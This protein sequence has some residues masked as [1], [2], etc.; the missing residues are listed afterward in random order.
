MR[1]FFKALAALSVALA[2]GSAAAQAAYPDK[3]VRIIVPFT[4]GGLADVLA[5]AVAVE[6]GKVWKQPV[7]VDNRPGAGTMIAGEATAKAPADGYTLLLANDATLSSNQYIYT[8][9]PY[10]PVKD[11]T[12]II[13]IANS[14]IALVAS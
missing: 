7:I 9:M 1:K 2:A 4:A 8:K 13:N 12:P 3:T 5:R 11:F 14:P 6:L 10:D